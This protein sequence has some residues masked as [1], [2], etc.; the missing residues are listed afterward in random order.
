LDLSH[1]LADIEDVRE[2]IKGAFYADL[3]RMLSNQEK[4]IRMTATEVAERHEEKLVMLGP[5]LGLLHNELLAPL[6][7]LTFTRMLKA[8]IMPAPP[9]EMQGQ[10]L[11]IEFVSMLAQAQRAIGTH[12]TDRFVASLGNI[13]QIKPEVLDKFDPDVWADEYA[14]MLGLNPELIVAGDRVALIR[15]QRAQQQQQA[16]QMAQFAQ[17]TQIAGQL[18]RSPTG[19]KNV[20]TD[21]LSAFS[22]Y[23]S[24]AP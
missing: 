2:R 14:D 1:L 4:D 10:E 11:N 5:V 18:A 19:E 7:E 3:F 24:A 17:G 13:A 8:Q 12:S 15:Q 16:Q 9:P 22:G 23:G 21:T 20:L 6:V